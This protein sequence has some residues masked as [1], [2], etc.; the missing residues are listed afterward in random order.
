MKKVK[1]VIYF[2]SKTKVKML[3]CI[4]LVLYVIKLVGQER[5]DFLINTSTYA[6]M[7]KNLNEIN[8]EIILFQYIEGVSSIKSEKPLVAYQYDLSV[9]Y[10]LFR[11]LAI[12]IDA[13]FHNQNYLQKG[14]IN[15]NDFVDRE[16]NYNFRRYGFGPVCHI[17]LNSKFDTS[18]KY[19]YSFLQHTNNGDTYF[20]P[21]E[22]NQ[23][24]HSLKLGF[25][26]NVNSFLRIG[27]EF[28]SAI[29]T[30]NM[31]WDELKDKVEFRPLTLGGGLVV[32]VRL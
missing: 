10:F 16:Q 1:V 30:D 25:N 2:N 8:Q 14:K 19:T 4:F 11:N 22:I 26:Y 24:Q 15:D 23:F 21:L 29:A 3:G 20:M 28:I 17:P 31:V 27:G 7:S 18:I 32:G 12:S 6:I 9:S 5:G 13:G